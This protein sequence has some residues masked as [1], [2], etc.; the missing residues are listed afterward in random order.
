M[1][2]DQ[3]KKQQRLASWIFYM[4]HR[5]QKHLNELQKSLEKA[6][7]N[8]NTNVILTGDFNCPDIIWD[9]A[10]ALGPDREIQQGLVDIAETYNLTQIHTI[11]TRE[12]NLL[13]LVFVTNPT[14]V[15]SSNNVPGISDHDIIITDLETKVHH[16]KSLP[17]KCYIYKKAKWDQITTDLKHTLEEV[18][19]KHHQGAEV[20]QLWDTF[21]SQLQKTMN[22]NIPNKEIRSRNNIPWI[23]HKQRENA[24]EKTE[25]IQTS[26]KNKQMV[27]L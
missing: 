19:E 22:T 11:P 24:K 23:K 21:K 6:R 20:H 16:Q 4:P 12:G 2:K 26:Q 10:T 18:K 14:L 27:K 17:R 5:D 1:G 9:T 8:G 13:D 7:T 25:A 15:K 3:N